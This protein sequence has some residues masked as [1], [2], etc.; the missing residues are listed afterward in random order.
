[1]KNQLAKIEPQPLSLPMLLINPYGKFVYRFDVGMPLD[2]LIAKL[3]ADK[4]EMLSMDMMMRRKPFCGT[5]NS[6]SFTL[7][8]LKKYTK[9]SW[10]PV[11]V[12]RMVSMGDRTRVDISFRLH[13]FVMV[14]TWVWIVF[15]STAAVTAI[16]ASD[17]KNNAF[18]Y[19]SALFPVFGIIVTLIGSFMGRADQS[20]VLTYFNE[21]SDTY[22]C[23]QNKLI[24]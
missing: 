20:A 17:S 19:F 5:I 6:D 4:A 1:V 3:K 13:V 22:Y 10:A 8:W 21:L 24:E 9:N 7:T 14:F 2:Q 16:V 12:G 18:G 23:E 15:A 11:A